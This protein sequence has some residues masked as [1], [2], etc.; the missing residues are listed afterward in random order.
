MLI[1]KYTNDREI[2]RVNALLHPPMFAKSAP[3][4]FIF[5][6]I[7]QVQIKSQSE[8]GDVR[9]Q[10]LALFGPLFDLEVPEDG[11]IF[12]FSTKL[13]TSIGLP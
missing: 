13:Q 3:A 5:Y 8:S 9:S 6:V 12:R 2:Y 4:P 7:K 11:G 1:G 10:Y